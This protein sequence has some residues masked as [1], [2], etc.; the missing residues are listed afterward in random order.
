ML[1][2]YRHRGIGIQLAEKVCGSIVQ[3]DG[4]SAS[5]RKVPWLAN[6]WESSIAK[7]T[8]TSPIHKFREGRSRMASVF[9]R[10]EP[11]ATSLRIVSRSRAGRWIDPW[12]V[13]NHL[14]S[15]F[16]SSSRQLGN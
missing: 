8:P 10:L 2:R 3:V 15:L 6:S 11:I 12:P 9:T 4:R 13:G 5:R 16:S 7:F 14:I 1:R